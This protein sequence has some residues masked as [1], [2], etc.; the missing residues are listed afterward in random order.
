VDSQLPVLV[1]IYGGSWD[2][3]DTSSYNASELAANQNVVVASFNY[4]VGPL[5]FASFAEQPAA[6]VTTGNFGMLD[7]QVT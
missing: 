2:F 6:G 7:M 4:R 5:G 1:F 3:D